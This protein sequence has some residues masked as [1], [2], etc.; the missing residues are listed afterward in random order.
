MHDRQAGRLK[1]AVGWPLPGGVGSLGCNLPS[2][3][4]AA[5]PFR[6][7][8]FAATPQGQSL[9]Y[10]NFALPS[11]PVNDLPGRGRS[12]EPTSTAHASKPQAGKLQTI[13]VIAIHVIAFLPCCHDLR[14]T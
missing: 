9:F 12:V 13:P 6:W 7:E 10:S 3:Q 4:V 14:D 11:S 8:V 1:T 2:L 5:V